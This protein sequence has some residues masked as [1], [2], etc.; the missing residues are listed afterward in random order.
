[1]NVIT[2]IISSSLGRKY[3]MAISGL[4]LFGFVVGHLLGNLQIFLGPEQ[5]NAY[6]AL[7]KANA[8]FLWSARIGLIAT[9]GVHI[10]MAVLLSSENK[11]ARPIDYLNSPAPTSA[12]YASRTMIVS[13][14]I[15]FFFVL[16]HLLHFTVMVDFINLTGKD[17]HEFKD[18]LGR[19]DI[20]SMLII[21]FRN[22]LV[23]VFYLVA[24][25][26]LCLHLTHGF[27]AMFQSLGLK[28]KTYGPL[29]DN[30]GTVIGVLLFIGYASIPLAVLAGI[31]GREVAR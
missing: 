19:H 23:S 18:I 31:V 15:V 11:A 22:P 20:Y 28:N 4:G 16:Y 17:F 21:G 26:L 12:S 13:G 6:G 25:A 27:G 29:I 14:L 2:N 7:L 9:I 10:W 30:A 5:I 24:L 1:M 3:L 8:G